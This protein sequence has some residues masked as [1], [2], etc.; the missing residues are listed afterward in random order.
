MSRIEEGIISVFSQ[1]NPAKRGEST[2]IEVLD[3]SLESG[4]EVLIEK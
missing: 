3:F 2:V 1:K 4:N